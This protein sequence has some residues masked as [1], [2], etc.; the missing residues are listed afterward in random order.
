MFSF[1]FEEILD[2]HVTENRLKS[3]A[4]VLV[5]E[6]AF[7]GREEHGGFGASLTHVFEHADIPHVS[8]NTIGLSGALLVYHLQSLIG[9]HY[10]NDVL[11]R[12]LLLPPADESVTNQ[13]ERR[14]I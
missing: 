8:V 3:A 11:L 13:P 6:K 9:K 2:L 7:D 10:G 4:E 12:L 1:L 5:L 14:D